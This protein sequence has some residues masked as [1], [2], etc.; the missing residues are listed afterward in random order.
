MRCIGYVTQPMRK[1]RALSEVGLVYN[2]QGLILNDPLSPATVQQFYNLPRQH[3]QLGPKCSNT[4]A[5]L[6]PYSAVSI[7]SAQ[8]TSVLWVGC[9]MLPPSSRVKGMVPVYRAVGR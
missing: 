5:T 1:Q 7:S 8:D 6:K 9:Y 2:V 3:C 4:Q